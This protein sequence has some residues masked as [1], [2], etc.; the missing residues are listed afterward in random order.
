MAVRAELDRAPAPALHETEIEA[1]DEPAVTALQLVAAPTWLYPCAL[2]DGWTDRAHAT[3][4][5]L[6]GGA[7]RVAE[8]AY[9]GPVGA[10]LV[11]A[12]QGLPE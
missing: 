11:P 8:L 3:M 5:P 6:A 9:A 2:R 1:V 10:G 4:A 7:D 12:Q